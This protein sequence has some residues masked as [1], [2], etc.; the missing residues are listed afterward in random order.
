MAGKK[1]KFV[2]ALGYPVEPGVLTWVVEK[3][4]GDH[5]A[6]LWKNPCFRTNLIC[7]RDCEE[8][9]KGEEMKECTQL[10]FEV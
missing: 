10:A 2:N 7:S 9:K 6:P 8:K 3:S 1:T 5:A 4:E